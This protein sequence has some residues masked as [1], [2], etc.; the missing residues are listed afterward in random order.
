MGVAAVDTF[1]FL[2]VL[3]KMAA[4]VMTAATS[5][6][7]TETK[8]TVAE[9]TTPEEAV[10]REAVVANENK[11]V[12]MEIVRDNTPMIT[13][14][15]LCQTCG[16]AAECYAECRMLQRL[17]PSGQHIFMHGIDIDSRT[18]PIR[19]RPTC[20]NCWREWIKV[21]RSSGNTVFCYVAMRLSCSYAVNGHYRME[22][23]API[24][25]TPTF[26]SRGVHYYTED[27]VFLSFPE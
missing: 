17:Q 25:T 6:A 24:G 15:L 7:A 13:P 10:F 22:N 2:V 20:A 1:L 9:V 18:H 5:S 27:E 8:A 14:R 12:E 26:T 4:T 23:Y 3:L 16:N 19:R 11:D 21:Q